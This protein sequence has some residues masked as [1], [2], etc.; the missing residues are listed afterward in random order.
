MKQ[1]IALFTKTILAAAVLWSGQAFATG[2]EVIPGEFLVKYKDNAFA[3]LL[4]VKSTSNVRV[5]SHNPFG[6]LFKVRLNPGVEANALYSLYQNQNVEYIVPNLKLRALTIPVEPTALQEQWA[7]KKVNAEAAWSRAGNKGSRNMLVAV[8]DTGIDYNHESLKE[9]MVPGYNFRDNNTDAM[10]K[11][12]QNPGHGTHCGGI[13]GATGKA[14][15]GT[16]G[17]SPEVSLMPV[18]FLGEDGSGDLD[19]AIKSL[20]F[21]VQKGAKVISN[22][23]GAAIPRAQAQPL[24]EAVKRADDAGAINVI[25]AANDGKSNDVTEVFP[26]NAGFP[27]TIVVAASGPNDEKPSWSNYGTATVHLAAPGLDI[28]STLPKGKYGKLSGTSMAT[29]LVSGLVAF[30]KAQDATLT[31][32]QARALLQ[33]TGAKANIE[34]ACNCRV[35]AMAATDYLLSGKMFITPA[36]ATIGVGE[37]M[38]FSGTHGVAPFSFSVADSS[39]GSIANDGI[40]TA[41]AK[42]QTTVTVKDANGQVST[43]LTIYVGKKSNGGGNPP[44][45]Q[46]DPGQPDPGNPGDP[47]SCPL[48][49]EALCQIM[50]QFQ[51]TLPWC[52]K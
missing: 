35:D 48:G 41:K 36:A 16:V 45:G 12:G 18:R 27:N 24:I 39:V 4:S 14:N 38:Q 19:G 9:N 46:P 13:I 22:S 8:V 42:G 6:H 7:I 11:T 3:S 28:M 1:R 34:T 44:P 29:P 50:C 37:T 30:L 26:A 51:P 5:V 52:Q 17:I 23:W 31:G 20:D 40:F 10:D 49:D 15:G 32:A 47:N 2:A 43:S 21:A 33:L 25:A